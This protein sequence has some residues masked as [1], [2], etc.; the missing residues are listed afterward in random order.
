MLR[1]KFNIFPPAQQLRLAFGCSKTT[2][3]E[4]AFAL[5]ELPAVRFVFRTVLC[6][7]MPGETAIRE[8]CQNTHELQVNVKHAMSSIRFGLL[9]FML[10]LPVGCGWIHPHHQATISTQAFIPKS[11]PPVTA[12]TKNATIRLSQHGGS[13]GASGQPSTVPAA[14]QPV[15][16][17]PGHSTTVV[18]K[19]V[20]LSAQ[21]SPGHPLSVAALL[22]TVNGHPIFVQDIIRPIAA[23][24]QHEAATS[25]TKNFFKQRALETIYAEIHTKIGNMLLY[26]AAR[27]QLSK[28][29]RQRIKIYLQAKREKILNQYMGSVALANRELKL[30]GTTLDKKLYHLRRQVTIQIY[31]NNLTFP[32]MV[33]TRREILRYYETHLSKFT[34][35]ASI[36]LYTISYP[37][38]RQWPRDPHD[39]N[40]LKPIA[41]PTPSQIAAARRKAI[42]YCVNLEERLR[43]GAS[44]AFLAEDN[45]VDPQADNGGHWPHTHRGSLTN[46]QIEKIAF[47]LKPHTMAPP[48]LLTNPGNPRLDMVEIIRVTKVTPHRVIPFSIAQRAIAKTLR[49]RLY[50]KLVG[51]YYR[52][53]YSN[54]SRTAVAEMIRETARVAVALYWMK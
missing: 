23:E 42:A 3:A 44:F 53:L 51:R 32:K 2:Y 52:H 35:H 40:H 49:L 7:N 24:L 22:G 10:M 14:T 17:L 1:Q 41:H 45:S 19:S 26:N 38:I 43:H 8:N 4:Y 20:P 46:A 18:V 34:R 47:S 12:T 30:A 13:A 9:G 21:I 16:P 29:D 48:V 27:R 5:G 31:L 50:R 15:S 36:N 39:P 54:S 28:D 25:R 33:V 6:S 37:V 11:A